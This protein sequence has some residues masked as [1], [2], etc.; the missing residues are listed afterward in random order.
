MTVLHNEYETVVIVRPDLDDNDTYEIISK[1]EGVID[2]NG[3]HMLIRDDWGKR[4]LAYPIA[5]HHKGHYVLLSHLAP[6]EM[7][8]EL[9]R[10]IG[11]EDRVLRFLTVRISD[12]VDVPA[13]LKLAEE[14][15]KVKDE[16][17]ERQRAESEQRAKVAEEERSR[18]EAEEAAYQ[19]AAEEYRATLEQEEGEVEEKSASKE[20]EG[21]P[22]AS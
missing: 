5:K 8:I 7:L 16:Q 2:D 9:E 18:K 12:S 11:I 21:E 14:E 3:G 17:A 10:N 22:S 15:R 13:R 6:T 20:E 4:K 1:F 19:A